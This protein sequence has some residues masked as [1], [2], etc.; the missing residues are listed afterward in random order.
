MNAL[1]RSAHLVIPRIKAFATPQIRESSHI[2]TK[3]SNNSDG[4]F[5]KNWLSDPGAYPVIAVVVFAC[6]ACVGRLAHALTTVPDVR[7]TP[8]ARQTLIRP[9]SS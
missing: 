9:H 3:L 2:P 8:S 5:T 6:T 7:F 4:N 1:T